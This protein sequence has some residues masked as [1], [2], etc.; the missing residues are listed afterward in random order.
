MMFWEGTFTRRPSSFLPDL[1]AIQSSPVLKK[2]LSIS[3]SV[4]DSGSHP[5]VFGPALLMVSP[6]TMTF[7]DNTGWTFHMGEWS[8]VTPSMR[9]FLQP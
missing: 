8:S 2:Q 3:T 6:R 5:S 4:Q 1:M 9:R 7:E